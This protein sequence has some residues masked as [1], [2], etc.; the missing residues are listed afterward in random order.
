MDNLGIDFGK[1]P[2][3]VPYVGGA[4]YVGLE[5]FLGKTTKVK[6]NSVLEAVLGG[7]GAFYKV[8]AS[9]KPPQV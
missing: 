1:L 7:L 9:Q 6:A 4:F 3:W 8:L 2:E 5:Y